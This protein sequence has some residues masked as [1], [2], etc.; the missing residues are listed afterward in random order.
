MS[1]DL[2]TKICS[3]V[4]KPETA[5]RSTVPIN[6]MGGVDKWWCQADKG[7]AIGGKEIFQKYYDLIST[8][9]KYIAIQ[10]FIFRKNTDEEPN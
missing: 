1:D 4:N 7:V 2:Y 9:K 5:S 10:T 8:A 3:E 6:K